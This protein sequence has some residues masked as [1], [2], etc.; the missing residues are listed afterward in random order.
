MS[1]SYFQTLQK[2]C[3]P[4]DKHREVFDA[5]FS[6]VQGAFNDDD[7]VDNKLL[8]TGQ[9]RCG[10]SYVLQTLIAALIRTVP[11]ITVVYF[12]SYY[13]KLDFMVKM[14]NVFR[15]CDSIGLKKNRDSLIYQF[16]IDDIRAFHCYETTSDL[17]GVSGDVLVVNNMLNKELY[18]DTILPILGLKKTSVIVGETTSPVLSFLNEWPTCTL[19]PLE[20]LVDESKS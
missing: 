10:V 17:R 19:P 1:G 5:C 12:A 6:V 20:Q 2:E 7:V 14:S 4:S 8:I 11:N 9:R 18:M 16:G 13:E 3:N 15:S